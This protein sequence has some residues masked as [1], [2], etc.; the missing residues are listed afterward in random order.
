[1][2]I[3]NRLFVNL[4]GIEIGVIKW[5]NSG[6]YFYSIFR[7]VFSYSFRIARGVYN[8]DIIMLLY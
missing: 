7:L 6:N 5:K 2:E 1:M 8:I 3:L 4:K